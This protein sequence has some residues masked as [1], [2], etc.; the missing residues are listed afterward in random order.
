MVVTSGKWSVLEW[1]YL[2][3]HCLNERWTM[4]RHY[5]K[6]GKGIRAIPDGLNWQATDIKTFSKKCSNLELLIMGWKWNE[7]FI[8][9]PILPAPWM[10]LQ[11]LQINCCPRFGNI[12]EDVELH[13]T[14]PNLQRIILEEDGEYWK[15]EREPSILPHLEGCSKL[16]VAV[17]HLGYFRFNEDTLPGEK[18]P[19]PQDLRVL[20]LSESKF[21]EEFMN[22]ITYEDLKKVLPRLQKLTRE[23]VPHWL[24]ESDQYRFFTI[25]QNT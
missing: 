19:L 10:S 15:Q 16:S 6:H 18:L 21:H 11:D 14:L 20:N 2:I 12:F 17:F 3:D 13:L 23:P 4:F 8:S 22:Q 9:W 1:K 5:D 25:L 7:D 24:V